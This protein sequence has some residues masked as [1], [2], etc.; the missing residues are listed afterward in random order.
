[1]TCVASYQTKPQGALAPRI[2]LKRERGWRMEHSIKTCCKNEQGTF[3]KEDLHNL[4]LCLAG[5]YQR[6][7]ESIIR[8]FWGIYAT[9]GCRWDKEALCIMEKCVQEICLPQHKII[10]EIFPKPS[11]STGRKLDDNELS[12]LEQEVEQICQAPLKAI[13]E[14]QAKFAPYQLAHHILV[15][16]NPYKMTNENEKHILQ[17]CEDNRTFIDALNFAMH[18]RDR[19]TPLIQ[20]FLRTMFSMSEGDC[21]TYIQ[22]NLNSTMQIEK[23]LLQPRLKAIIDSLPEDVKARIDTSSIMFEEDSCSYI[24][25]ILGHSFLLRYL[26]LASLKRECDVANKAARIVNLLTILFETE[27]SIIC[28]HIKTNPE[29]TIRDYLS[30][31]EKPYLLQCL[32]G[33]FQ[34]ACFRVMTQEEWEQHVLSFI[35]WFIHS[36]AQDILDT[37]ALFQAFY[38]L[39]DKVTNRLD[40]FE[41]FEIKNLTNYSLLLEI[42]VKIYEKMTK[43][44]LIWDMFCH[45]L[46]TKPQIKF[47][48]VFQNHIEFN[49]IQFKDITRRIPAEATIVDL[50][51]YTEIFELVASYSDLQTKRALLHYIQ[52]HT[53]AEVSITHLE[54][55]Q[56]VFKKLAQQPELKKNPFLRKFWISS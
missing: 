21:K 10:I 47:K 29:Q 40:S 48:I 43:Q 27:N 50:K 12:I 39:V 30:M 26:N 54:E 16:E 56:E 41:S 14:S 9:K 17:L 31:G 35:S 6:R 3:V 20:N 53:P 36:Q 8:I 42:V 34:N 11:D 5:K 1:M 23:N 22:R 19:P 24:M 55:F 32:W 46:V 44:D 2:P 28:Q 45:F 37:E 33:L 4:T 7:Y 15:Q 38:P 18:M 49:M 51:K 25:N 13:L 52:E